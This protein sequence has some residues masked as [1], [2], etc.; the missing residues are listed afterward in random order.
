MR[1]CGYSYEGR[2]TIVSIWGS[3]S[4][5]TMESYPSDH[6]VSPATPAPGT[7]CW[8]CSASSRWAPSAQ[9][10]EG[11]VWLRYCPCYLHQPDWL[12][13]LTTHYHPDCPD[14]PCQTHLVGFF[15]SCPPR[16]RVHIH[17]LTLLFDRLVVQVVP[18]SGYPSCCRRP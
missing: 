3:R 18:S 1:E 8:L 15:E 12:H 4:E 17:F 5:T 2:L 14:Y 10:P 13:T 11:Y 9:V 7:H 6:H 16:L